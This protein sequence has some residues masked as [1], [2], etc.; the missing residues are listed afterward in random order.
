[1]SYLVLARPS[2]WIKNILVFAPIFFVGGVG[3]YRGM[4]SVCLTFLIFTCF[5]VVAYT[6]NDIIDRE[7]DASHPVKCFRPVASGTI[8]P[9][10][11]ALFAVIIFSFA[12]WMTMYYIPAIMGI[13][14]AYCLLV[15]L[16]IF[17][18]KQIPIVD[19]LAVTSFYLLRVS[20]GGAAIDIIP[21]RWLVACVMFL[22]LFIVLGK[23]RAECGHSP[24]AM[25]PVLALYN[26]AETDG[27]K[28]MLDRFLS[29][30]AAVTIASYGA[31][32]ILAVNSHFA[33]YSLFFVIFGIFR[34]CFLVYHSALAESAEIALMKDAPLFLSVFGWGIFMYAVVYLL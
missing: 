10:H 26:A 8:S 19:V 15:I 11:A 12:I 18:L 2:Q 13:M 24:S 34:Y 23:R 5:S 32:T 7:K 20:A 17:Y 22:S 31:Y 30:A 4:Q 16:Y 29:V 3:N 21:S 9:A 6:V 28:E 25:R 14:A 33:I 1:M 27:M